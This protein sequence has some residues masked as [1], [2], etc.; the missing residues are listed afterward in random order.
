MIVSSG[1][2]TSSALSF[3]RGYISRWCALN[4]FR[5]TLS[6]SRSLVMVAPGILQRVLAVADQKLDHKVSV[7]QRMRK[8][9]GVP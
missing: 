6:E 9:A 1:L 8:R 7:L 3:H 4:F 5:S 2:L